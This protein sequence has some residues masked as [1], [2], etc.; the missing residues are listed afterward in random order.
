MVERYRLK[1]VHMWGG[2]IGA[3]PG[4]HTSYKVNMVDARCL[5]SVRRHFHAGVRSFFGLGG[6]CQTAHMKGA[7]AYAEVVGILQNIRL[8]RFSLFVQV[9]T[10]EAFSGPTTNGTCGQMRNHNS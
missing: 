9:N 10:S 1:H 6:G 4:F 5:L 3:R 2:V 8:F 7:L